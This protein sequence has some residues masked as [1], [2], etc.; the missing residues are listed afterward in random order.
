M[1]AFWKKYRL[2][3]LVASVATLLSTAGRVSGLVNYSV[4]DQWIWAS[5]NFASVLF[6]WQVFGGIHRYLNRVL[7]FYDG[8]FI[9]LAAQFAC[10]WTLLGSIHWLSLYYLEEHMPVKLNIIHYTMM[11]MIDLVTALGIT[12]A[13]TASYFFNRWKESLVKNERLEKEKSRMQFHHL[14]N[15]V[16]PHF[17]F[18]A[19]SALDGLIKT[20]PELA[21]RFLQH[22]SKVYRYS[23][24]YEDRDCVSLD[25][26]LGV[27]KHFT[28][29]LEM[30]YGRALHISLHLTPEATEKGIVPLTLEMLT[31]N[32]LKHNR[33]T[34]DN[35]LYIRIFNSGDELV[36]ENSL[37]K[38]KTMET[39]N[40]KGL[41]QLQNLYSYLSDKPFVI[42]GEDGEE[43][44]FRVKMPLL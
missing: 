12:L 40:G 34:E 8:V 23:L 16:N 18:N 41:Q 11:F 21:S 27:F 14:R 43:G 31:E 26:E 10:N 2:R 44:L 7:P 1:K 33:V 15:R 35:P 28:S 37:Q 22:L 19:L 3:F 38:K 39:S 20:Q 6:F 13:F 42:E 25:T 30:R 17:L 24:Q 29:L 4:T 5:I 9:R 36:V 32:A